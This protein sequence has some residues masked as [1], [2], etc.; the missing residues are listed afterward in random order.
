MSTHDIDVEYVISLEKKAKK[1]RRLVLEIFNNAGGGHF[2]GCLSIVEI[3]VALYFDILKINPENPSWEERD[4]FILSKGHAAATFITVLAEAGFISLEELSEFN[5]FNSNLSTHTDRFK[6]PGCEVSCGS[7]G[8]GLS[9][10]GGMALAAKST[11]KEHRVF[12]LIGDG[13]NME[14]MIWEGAMA[15]A[16]YKLDNL[17]CIVDRNYMMLDGPTEQIM[18]LEPLADKWRSFGWSCKQ[19]DGHNFTEILHSLHTVPW[20]KDHPSVL[21]ADTVKG[22]GVPFIE[23][24]TVWHYRGITED[25][26]KRALA[27]LSTEEV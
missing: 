5:Q 9:I 16:H 8:H 6:I 12:C 23:N 4:R 18:R 22:K 1:I 26:Y 25:E 3:L 24:E 10:A 2:G 11:G 17:T 27:A 15:A 19:I 7:L 14:G 13:E 21:I 20:K